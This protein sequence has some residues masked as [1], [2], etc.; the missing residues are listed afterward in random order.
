MRIMAAMLALAGCAATPGEP[1]GSSAT[2]PETT[3]AGLGESARLGDVTVRPL[4][5]LED[6]R[7][8]QDVQCVWAGRVRLR[9]AIS[10]V[11]GESEMVLGEPFAL[12]R[13]GAVT[14]TAVEPARWHAPPPGV[15]ADAPPR[16]AF[17]R[18]PD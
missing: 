10:G 5:I 8:P 12:P 13:G 6:S 1:A 14:L 9:A 7:C 2:A 4:A 17:I 18:T 3:M 15:D 11:P 16:F